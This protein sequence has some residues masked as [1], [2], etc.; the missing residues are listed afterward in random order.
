M[1]GT[2]AGVAAGRRWRIDAWCLECTLGVTPDSI[3]GGSPV[4]LGAD[5]RLGCV[6]QA[7]VGS[8]VDV[9]SRDLVVARSE[10]VS[11]VDSIGANDEWEVFKSNGQ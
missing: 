4:L 11:K 1:S 3:G 6:E 9:L 2:G 10:G 7:A 5:D 8:L